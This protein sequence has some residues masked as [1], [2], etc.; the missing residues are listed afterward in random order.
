MALALAAVGFVGMYMKVLG[1][2]RVC[3]VTATIREAQV[4][5]NCIPGTLLQYICAS[6]LVK[7]IPVSQ[8]G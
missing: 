7:T 1:Q 4:H 8:Q 3:A 2:A 5:N 6:G